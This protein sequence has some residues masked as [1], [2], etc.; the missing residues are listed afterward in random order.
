MF[1]CCISMHDSA[2]ASKV[3]G[4]RNQKHKITETHCKH[5]EYTAQSC[6]PIR[7]CGQQL[8][9]LVA[10]A[11]WQTWVAIKAVTL[12]SP[13]PTHKNY[14]QHDSVVTCF[15]MHGGQRA[16]IVVS[17]N[18]TPKTDL[19]GQSGLVA[20]S[21]IT[22]RPWPTQVVVPKLLCP[23]CWVVVPKLLCPSC[24]AQVV[25]PKLLSPSCC[26]VGP[27]SGATY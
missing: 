3:V 24:C 18:V 6:S 27:I 5:F 25:V 9:E 10:L 1:A 4:T 14:S 12:Q 20:G 7:P 8:E 19:A 15:D 11:I 17:V 22:A 21:K 26:L 23:S 16:I 2:A 13:L